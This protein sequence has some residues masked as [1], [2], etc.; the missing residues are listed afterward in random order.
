MRKLITVQTQKGRLFRLSLILVP[1]LIGLM[2]GLLLYFY[3]IH[4]TPAYLVFFLIAGVSLTS[5]FG[6]SVLAI[7]VG[8]G[9]GIENVL[10]F[11]WGSKAP[12]LYHL[13]KYI[14]ALHLQDNEAADFFFYY[15]CTG[16][17]LAVIALNIAVFVL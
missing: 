1:L 5:T 14:E 2:I 9:L 6:A 15:L 4:R 10:V 13:H 8:L 12:E 11:I 16:I 7:L 17:I 3:G